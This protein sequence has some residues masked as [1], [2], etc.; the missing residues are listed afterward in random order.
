M[1][2][3]RGSMQTDFRAVA[4]LLAVACGQEAV[5]ANLGVRPDTYQ[6]MRATPGASHYRRP[7]ADWRDRLRPLARTAVEWYRTHA[8][9]VSA[10]LL[11]GT[12]NEGGRE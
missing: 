12:L 9:A 11:S 1:F 2:F 4:S 10:E 5:A 7:P 8:D 3:S 6:K